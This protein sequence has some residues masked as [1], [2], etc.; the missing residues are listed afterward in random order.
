[1]VPWLQ[2]EGGGVQAYRPLLGVTEPKVE[3][4]LL[5]QCLYFTG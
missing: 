3:M 5:K 2:V 4:F 1:M